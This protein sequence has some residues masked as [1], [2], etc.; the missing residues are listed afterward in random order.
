[1]YVV[2]IYDH[3]WNILTQLF[4]FESLKI[5]EKINNISTV[6]FEIP[7]D[8]NCK[9]EFFKEYNQVKIFKNKNWKE[10]ELFSWI[11][12]S[13]KST[14]DQTSVSLNCFHLLLR[15]KIIYTDKNYTD[16]IK[17]IIQDIINEINSRDENFIEEFEC[18]V[19]EEVTKE[20]KAKRTFFDILWDLAGDKYEF[21][22]DWK[23][24]I[25]QETI[26][27]D[28]SFWKNIVLFE[29]NINSPESRTINW[30]EFEYDSDHIVNAVHWEDWQVEDSE[31]IS[32]FGRLEEW[33]TSWIASEIL[34]ERKNS[35][36]ELNI[37]SIIND[38]SIC[39]LWDIVR[40]YID[41]WNDIMQFDWTLKV[42]EKTLKIWWVDSVE[43]KLNVWKITSL[44]LRDTLSSMN[45][46]I[47]NLEL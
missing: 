45:S 5:V 38:F 47:K 1:M 41:T 25:F 15:K 11:I 7:N 30:A 21:S 35:V 28:K 26:W 34:E 44:W 39:N 12:R 37:D 10:T 19:V 31:S 4:K 36:K 33:F 18:D 40:V 29:Y 6:D 16:S 20:Y 24:L 2:Y 17:N 22:F 14:F 46:R 3:L 8:I 9:Y 13:V 23:K 32:E 27:E 43:I 42:I